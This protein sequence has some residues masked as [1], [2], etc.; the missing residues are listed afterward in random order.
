MDDRS[1]LCKS[2][3]HGV[4]VPETLAQ[5][6]KPLGDRLIWKAGEGLRAGVDLDTGNDALGFERLGE[7]SAVGTLLTNCFVIH[8]GAAD[9][10]SS[11][12]AGKEH[13]PIGAPA[14]LGR[15]DP[16]RLKPLRQ[17]G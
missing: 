1:P 15:L 12:R 14:L 7:R 16:K 6:V 5:A 4:V 3:T 13:F 9:E 10:L 11:V 17:R 8:D 2:G